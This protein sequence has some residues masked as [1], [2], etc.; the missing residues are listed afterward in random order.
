MAT[1]FGRPPRSASKNNSSS[2]RSPI[3]YG[4]SGSGSIQS[5]P[6]GSIND[7]TSFQMMDVSIAIDMMEGLV[8]ECNKGKGET[9]LGTSPVTAVIS[10]M[11]NVS[12]SRQIATHV[13]SLPLSTP[14]AAFSDKQHNFLVRWPADFDPHGDAL[15]TF[16][17]SRLMKR[18]AFYSDY[19]GAGNG[20]NSGF[21]PE[22]IELTI[23]IMRGSEM[24]TL[25]KAN[26]VITGN[27]SQEV[28]F[29][30]PISNTKDVL[31]NNKK[32]DSS[33][34][35]RTSSNVF[36]KSSKSNVKVLKPMAFP[37]D[38]RRKYHL[39]T[40]AMIR[41]QVEIIPQAGSGSFDEF[42]VASSVTNSVS[43]NESHRGNT[44]QTRSNSVSYSKTNAT[45]TTPNTRVDYSSR[46]NSGSFNTSSKEDTITLGTASTDD[47]GHHNDYHIRQQKYHPHM[48]MDE[49][50]EDFRKVRLVPEMSRKAQVRTME[51]ARQP[52]H[53]PRTRASSQRREFG[54]E[55]PSYTQPSMGSEMRSHHKKVAAPVP[56]TGRPSSRHSNRAFGREVPS[57]TQHLPAGPRSSSSSRRS[58]EPSHETGYRPSS[59]SGSRGSESYSQHGDPGQMNP[60][61]RQL[62]DYQNEDT[63][64]IVHHYKTR[65]ANGERQVEKKHHKKRP[66]STKPPT[67]NDYQ[68]ED[69]ENIV[70]HYKTR[71]ANDTYQ[72]E[73]KQHKKRPSSKPP[74]ETTTQSVRSE[75]PMAWLYD[76]LVGKPGDSHDDTVAKNNQTSGKKKTSSNKNRQGEERTK[77][78]ET[79]HDYRRPSTKRTMRV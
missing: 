77:K 61:T 73:K 38:N 50:Q 45:N 55:M 48:P 59:R 53:P 19:D 47:H 25:G 26:L 68:N 79:S 3:P 15:S 22:E 14:S 58:S 13:P 11:K 56:T 21:V 67:V 63:E 49:L 72:V 17:L 40:H 70:H 44:H 24:I 5:I 42:G 37:G 27:E 32:R 71:S 43:F 10:C 31:S 57:L 54:T 20:I 1:P 66:S 62:Y 2:S 6:P 64:N 4:R 28:V 12:N 52:P 51:A 78:E 46:G 74:P 29:D 8:M 9:P 18:D 35:N 65:S 75:S 41:L 76:K 39:N 7:S 69:T 16:K 30:L 36:I 60:H 23:G 34:L 33:P